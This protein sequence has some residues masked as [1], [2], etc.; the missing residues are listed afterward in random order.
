[1][2]RPVPDHEIYSEWSRW[3]PAG[4]GEGLSADTYTRQAVLRPLRDLCAA[5]LS[6]GSR[7][8]DPGRVPTLR[9]AMQVMHATLGPTN[10][11]RW[12]YFMT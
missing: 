11:R 2:T 10:G 7:G 5:A 3:D 1:M 8:E 12:R 9:E 6:R 4:T